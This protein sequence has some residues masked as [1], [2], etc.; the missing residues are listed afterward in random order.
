MINSSSSST[1]HRILFHVGM[2]SNYRPIQKTEQ[3]Q[4]T[5]WR[6]AEA[7]RDKLILEK[8]TIHEN[9][10]CPEQFISP[11]FIYVQNGGTL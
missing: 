5:N 8:Q 6:Q 10:F 9:V 4:N 11:V 1:R 2:T 7:E 3:Y